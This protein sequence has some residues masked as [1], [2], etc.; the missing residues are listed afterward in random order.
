V[1]KLLV[2]GIMLSLCVVLFASEDA[3]DNILTRHVND[4]VF[5]DGAWEVLTGLNIAKSGVYIGCETSG[6][7]ATYIHTFGGNGGG[8]NEH[9]VYDVAAGTWATGASILPGATMRYGSSVTKGNFIYMFAGYGETPIIIWDIAGDSGWISSA[10]IPTAQTNR[11]AAVLVG[12]LA[13]IVGGGN[14]WTAGNGV[15][16]YDI[17]GDTTFTGTNL[18]ANRLG[19]ALGYLGNDS[20]IYS[21]GYDGT[22]KHNTTWLGY[23]NPADPS[24]ITWTAGDP[25]P[26]DGQYGGGFGSFVGPTAS[27]LFIAGGN[28]NSN[29]QINLAFKYVSGA[30]W[31]ALPNKP[32]SF[33]NVAG[34]VAPSDGDSAWF[35]CAG[36]YSPYTAAFER[37]KSDY[38]FTP[39]TGGYSWDFEDGWQGWTHTSTSVFPAA[40]DVQASDYKPAYTCPD[41][42]DSSMWI[43]SDAAGSMTIIDTASS[44]AFASFPETYL[45]WAYSYN[46]V[47]TTDSFG[48]LIGQWSG[49]VLTWTKVAEYL[50]DENGTYD[51]VD[52]SGY[53]ADS[54]HVA[55]YYEGS[56]DYYAAFDNI[57]PITVL[58]VEET[59]VEMPQVFNYR[60]LSSNPIANS[61]VIEFALPINGTVNFTVYD[62]TGR[63]ILVQNHGVLNAGVHSLT[64]NRNDNS[65]RQVAA[66]SYF[67]RLEAAGNVVTGKFVVTE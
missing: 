26:A 13:Y 36:G 7:I 41:A 3:V 40:W 14:G 44:P 62:V 9:Q 53:S 43:D 64:W 51:S 34:V 42:G 32:T 50:V 55:F 16:V 27:V 25:Y 61:A 20:L 47:T 49:G 38:L 52:V 60:M 59:P 2:I 11:S 23:I 8:T 65:G 1:K 29:A 67:F 30:G 31:T 17:N 39:S 21:C 45:K 37:Y 57:G 63:T 54:F 48:V 66:G 10:T 19:G 12:D 6:G 4:E 28:N 56:Y 15:T 35:Y 46:E 33:F 22:S 58:G 24:D 5:A 18:P